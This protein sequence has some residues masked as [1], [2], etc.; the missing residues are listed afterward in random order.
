MGW[1]P[2]AGRRS[3]QGEHQ[4]GLIRRRSDAHFR[5][6]QS[7]ERPTGS[8][9]IG[10]S[11]AMSRSPRGSIQIPRSG[12]IEKMPPRTSRRPAGMRIQ[13]ASGWRRL[14]N[15][16]ATFPGTSCS[17]LLNARLRIALPRYLPS[18]SQEAL[19]RRTVPLKP[20]APHRLWPRR[21]RSWPR[22]KGS[23]CRLVGTSRPGPAMPLL[24]GPLP[25]ETVILQ[26][27]TLPFAC[28]PFRVALQRVRVAE[29]TMRILA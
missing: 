27:C 12:R 13:R 20:T 21:C 29:T 1:N 23:K 22:C 4:W 2:A 25:R 7:V 9:R 26:R 16:R 24:F 6:H 19:S 3:A 14:R 17:R 10:T 8:R 28:A 18:M 5:M 11:Y 15:T